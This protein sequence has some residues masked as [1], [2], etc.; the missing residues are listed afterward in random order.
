MKLY[1]GDGED[2]NSVFVDEVDKFKFFIS[3]EF[4]SHSSES[5]PHFSSVY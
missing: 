5:P 3:K 2:V 4:P 1:S